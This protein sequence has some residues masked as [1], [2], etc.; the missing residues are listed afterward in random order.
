MSSHATIEHGHSRLGSRL[1]SRRIRLVLAIVAI[2]GALVL[3]DAIP[4]WSVLVLAAA[5]LAVYIGLARHS[6]RLVVR[7]AS[8]IAA[9]SQLVV[10]LVPAAALVLTT[11]A[12][13]LIVVVAI[14]ALA[15]L[16]FERR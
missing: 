15:L 10:V 5:A 12:L 1:R 11:L 8:W 14:G 4:W 13:I 16:L 7:E 3:L 6:R 9:V 2:E